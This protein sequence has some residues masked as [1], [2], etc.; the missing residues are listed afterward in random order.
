MDQNINGKNK[1]IWQIYKTAVI[2]SSELNTTRVFFY[3]F[4]PHD[5]F[6]QLILQPTLYDPV[7]NF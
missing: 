1:I 2:T 5:P 6:G 7:L 4:D 3:A